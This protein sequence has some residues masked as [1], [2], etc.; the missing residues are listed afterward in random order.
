MRHQRA[1]ARAEIISRSTPLTALCKR[2]HGLG[3]VMEIDS[4]KLLP[5]AWQTPERLGFMGTAD[6]QGSAYLRSA[7]LAV[8]KHFQADPKTSFEEL[9]KE[10]REG[11]LTA[12]AAG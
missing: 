2:C 10:V 11:F 12:S 3:T 5:D 4:L 7:L 9:P 1:A 6:K 8:C